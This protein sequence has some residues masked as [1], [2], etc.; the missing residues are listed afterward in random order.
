LWDVLDAHPV[1]L[2][3]LPVGDVRGVTRELAGDLSDGAQ[4]LEV[5]LTAVDADTQHEVGVLELLRLEGGGAPAVDAG[6]ALGI[7]APPAEPTTQVLRVDA[8]E[9][10]VRVDAL[11]P[12]SNVERVVVLLHPLVRVERF[13]L[14]EGPLSLAGV[15]AR[16]RSLLG[17]GG[18]RRHGRSRSRCVR[19]TGVAGRTQRRRQTALDTWWWS[20][21]SRAT[22]SMPGAWTEAV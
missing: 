9:A 20:T 14:G 10:G 22:S 8:V 3:V 2:D 1:Q 17:R 5:E 19:G 21:C 13:E 12:G 18:L 15:P 6:L 11:D 4:L 16:T 7:E